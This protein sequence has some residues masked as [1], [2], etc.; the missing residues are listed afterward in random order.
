MAVQYPP[1]VSSLHIFP[2]KC[3]MSFLK[4]N[5]NIFPTD[6]VVQF[7]LAQHYFVALT[8]ILNGLAAVLQS[9]LLLWCTC[10]S[11]VLIL[12]K[13]TIKC[14]SLL[15]Q[16]DNYE[17]ATYL[18]NERVMRI[19]RRSG[20][21]YCSF[22]TKMLIKFCKIF[23]GAVVCKGGPSLFLVMNVRCGL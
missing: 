6:F 8:G 19:I 12:H 13:P 11:P 14:Q 16:I 5:K 23:D 21:W 9:L 17:G 22:I 1:W 7:P 2:H 10:V 3:G 20:L 4:W 15:Q 18:S